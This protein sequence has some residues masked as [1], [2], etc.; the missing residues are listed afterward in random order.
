MSD[1]E[2]AEHT[3]VKDDP[4]EW[5]GELKAEE[6]PQTTLRQKVQFSAV[7]VLN[8]IFTSFI[9]YLI[10]GNWIATKVGAFLL[11]AYTSYLLLMVWRA[12]RATGRSDRRR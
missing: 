9:A 5:P 2:R 7:I 8:W 6:R 3:H 12:R 11:A 1:A 10:S 4:Q